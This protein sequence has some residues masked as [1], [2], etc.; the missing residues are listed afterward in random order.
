MIEAS[1]RFASE[2][3]QCPWTEARLPSLLIVAR[4]C[5]P[6]QEQQ[7]EEEVET[8]TPEE[9]TSPFRERVFLTPHS[10]PRSND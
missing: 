9:T 4:N 5:P 1:V 8:S 6:R 10:K 2:F 7:E 3:P